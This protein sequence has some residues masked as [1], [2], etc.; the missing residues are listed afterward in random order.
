MQPG[1]VMGLNGD[2]RGR[3]GKRPWDKKAGCWVTLGDEGRSASQPR[4][5]GRLPRARDAV[6]G[7]MSSVS[8]HQQDSTAMDISVESES[9]GIP[10]CKGGMQ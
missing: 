2:G 3:A 7:H 8:K 4:L 5:E 1:S 6:R 10:K 9:R